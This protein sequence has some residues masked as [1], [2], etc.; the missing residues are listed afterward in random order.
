MPLKVLNSSGGNAFVRYSIED[1][2]WLMST[3]EG[4]P[5]DVS[6]AI[7]E[8]P[9]YIDIANIQLGWL[10]LTGGRDW[11]V[12]E[13]NDPGKLGADGKLKNPKPT[14]AHKQGFAVQMYSKK[15]FGEDEPQREFNSSQVGMLEFI[16]KLYDE[17][18]N[19]FEDG[20]AAVIQLTGASRVKIGKGSSRIPTYKFMG[21]NTNPIEVRE[22]VGTPMPQETQKLMPTVE[23][24]TDSAP[25]A[26]ATKSD[27]V[28]FDEI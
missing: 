14:D 11:V 16:K 23:Q 28:N 10:K 4:E 5:Q 27:D 12:W 6:D 24:A 7:M 25:V 13:D 18:E 21:M 22:N 9:I 1:N 3:P 8:N 17:L 15:V 19:S 2:M 26:S 20:K